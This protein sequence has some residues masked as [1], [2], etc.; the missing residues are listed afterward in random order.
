M[1]DDDKF[2]NVVKNFQAD[3]VSKLNDVLE[4]LPQGNK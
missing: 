3:L 2:F 1:H 4:A